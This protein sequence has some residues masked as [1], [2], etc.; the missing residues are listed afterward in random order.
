M[1]TIVEIITAIG[2]LITA[3]GGGLT[4]AYVV[5]PGYKHTKSVH[6]IVNQ[7]RTDMI[8]HQKVL[9]GL[10]IEHGITLPVQKA[11]A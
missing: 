3:I 11:D 6:K 4:V 7:Q 10:L 5:I 2:S 9:E 1:N 8:A